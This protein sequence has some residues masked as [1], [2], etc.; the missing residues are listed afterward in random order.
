MLLSA[1]LNNKMVSGFLI[2]FLWR[3]NFLDKL[4]NENWETIFSGHILP[5]FDDQNSTQIS[6]KNSNALSSL[7]S[8]KKYKNSLINISPFSY[9]LPNK[10]SLAHEVRPLIKNYQYNKLINSLE[11]NQFKLV[12]LPKFIYLSLQF[13]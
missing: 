2:S 11:I 7:N 1:E 12:L 10:H 8:Q 6:I 9:Q 5:K 3:F 4:I 13:E